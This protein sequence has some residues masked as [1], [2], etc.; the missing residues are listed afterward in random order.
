M[1]RFYLTGIVSLSLLFATFNARA[2]VIYE[3]LPGTHSNLE[4]ISSTLDNFGQAP[5]F[6]VAD[7]F[8][9]SSNEV[10][11]DVHWWGESNSGGNDFQFTFYADNGGVPGAIVQTSGGSLSTGIVNVGS[12][13]DP[14]N[15]YSSVL[16]SPFDVQAGTTYWLSVFNQAPDAS[17]LWL[18]ADAS[19]NGSRFGLIPGPPWGGSIPDMA[20]QLTAVPEPGTLWL[21]ATG[22]TVFVLR[23]IA[24]TRRSVVR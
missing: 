5:G 12:G 7:D 1:H 6:R 11:N 19:G 2:D 10:I 21:L 15:F 20:F 3:Q 13:F 16:G 24:E 22:L 14:V 17:W 18:R 9:L 8:V 4:I 23:R